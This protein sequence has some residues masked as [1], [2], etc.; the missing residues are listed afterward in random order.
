[1]EMTIAPGNRGTR[2]ALFLSSSFIATS[3]LFFADSDISEGFSKDTLIASIVFIALFTSSQLGLSQL[4][5]KHLEGWRKLI[6]A[7]MGG[8]LAAFV[9]YVSFYSIL[10]LIKF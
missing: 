1:M 2:I 7:M 10:Y 9:F 6:V 3:F 4:I 8:L 5:G